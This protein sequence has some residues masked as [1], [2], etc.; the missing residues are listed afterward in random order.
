LGEGKVEGVEAVETFPGTSVQGV[1]RQGDWETRRTRENGFYL[2]PITY[3]L[4][5]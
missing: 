4:R 5:V 3:F 2:L 1:G